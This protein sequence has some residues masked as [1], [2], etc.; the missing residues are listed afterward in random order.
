MQSAY[1]VGGDNV[2]GWLDSMLDSSISSLPTTTRKNLVTTELA[3]NLEVQNP[4]EDRLASWFI[5]PLL[6]LQTVPTGPQLPNTGR[7]FAPPALPG[8][9]SDPL[10]STKSSDIAFPLVDPRW[11]F[12][13]D[14]RSLMPPGWSPSADASPSV[15]CSWSPDADKGTSEQKPK[16]IHQRYR[17][18]KKKQTRDLL[19][20]AQKKVA[21]LNR[22]TKENEE[23]K[24]TAVVLEK[25]IKHRDFVTALLKTHGPLPAGFGYCPPEAVIATPLKRE[26]LLKLT[27]EHIKALTPEQ[28]RPLWKEL[29]QDLCGSVVALSGPDCPP[30]TAQRLGSICQ[31]V[32]CFCSRLAALNPGCMCYFSNTNLESNQLEHSSEA[33]WREVLRQLDLSLDKRK[34]MAVACKLFIQK[35][36]K[37]REE[38]LELTRV[39]SEHQLAQSLEE[40]CTVMC[41]HDKHQTAEGGPPGAHEVLE[42]IHRCLRRQYDLYHMINVYFFDAILDY[43]Q[44]AQVVVHAWPFFPNVPA[45]SMLVYLEL[46]PQVVLEDDLGPG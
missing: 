14:I 40:K 19:Q 37:V 6:G 33:H 7:S 41:R 24:L 17:E 10:P 8:F 26:A 2:L 1:D 3:T 4:S 30:E 18:R 45:L 25:L 5:D 32:G 39:W 27:P 44:L 35:S 29:V 12:G 34:E 36:L 20:E 43:K 11:A 31:P 9:T 13:A 16:S 23:L 15:P 38:R 22:L 28:V 42:Q 21:E 46:N